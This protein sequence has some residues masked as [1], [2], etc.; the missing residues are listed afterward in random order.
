M[1]IMPDWKV[2]VKTILCHFEGKRHLILKKSAPR[3][4]FSTNGPVGFTLNQLKIDLA[5]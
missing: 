5:P 4:R 3:R 1:I 2:V